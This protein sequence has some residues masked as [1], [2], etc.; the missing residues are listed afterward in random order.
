ML[1][2]QVRVDQRAM[3][4]KGSSAFLKTLASLEPHHQFV[5][6]HIQNTDCGWSYPSAELQSVYSSASAEIQTVNLISA[7][8]PDL[9]IINKKKKSCRIDDFAV[10]ADHTMKIKENL[11]RDKYL[12]LARELKRYGT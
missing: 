3:E 7:R 12:H 5:W 11:K 9:E 6:C 2:L 8:R 10:L 4:M 1:P